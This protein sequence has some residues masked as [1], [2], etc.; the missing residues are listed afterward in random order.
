MANVQ[1]AAD[2]FGNNASSDPVMRPSTSSGRSSNE[3]IGGGGSRREI[4]N[5][6][7]AP[8]PHSILSQAWKEDLDAGFLLASLFEL[9]GE[10]IFSFIQP[11]EMNVFL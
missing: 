3:S 7:R 2:G 9:F 8:K 4:G 1:P 5:S 11:V 10:G 6:S